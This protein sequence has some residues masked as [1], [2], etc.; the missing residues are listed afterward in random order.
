M[1]TLM[2]NLRKQL[3]IVICQLLAFVLLLLPFSAWAQQVN[4]A[5]STST[6]CQKIGMGARAA[7]MGESYTAVADDS[8][9]MFWN[10]AGLILARGTELSQTHGAWMLGVTHE[11]FA[12]SQNLM[13]DG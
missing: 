8:T 9:A 6:N 1:G 12:F 11:S 10:P 5:G 2:F 13:T 3:S 7:G 4:G